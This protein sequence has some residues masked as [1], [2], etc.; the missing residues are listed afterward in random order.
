MAIAVPTIA[1]QPVPVVPGV[2]IRSGRR[3]DEVVQ[4]QKEKWPFDI[5]EGKDH[6]VQVELMINDKLRHFYPE[7][8][9]SKIL[10]YLVQLAENTTGE[11][12]A[13]SARR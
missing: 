13:E 11:I 3:N 12:L 5:V 8:I 10:N 9:I 6:R 1:A 4:H 2:D 7:Y